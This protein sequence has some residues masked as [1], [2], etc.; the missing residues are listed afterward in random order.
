N[1]GSHPADKTT[2]IV[3]SKGQDILRNYRSIA[4]LTIVSAAIIA[5]SFGPLYY[6]SITILICYYLLLAIGW[7][8]VAGYTGLPSFAQAAFANLAGYASALAISYTNLPVFFGI[9]V[10]FLAIGGAA[11]VVGYGSVRLTGS[12]LALATISFSEG[13]RHTLS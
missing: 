7:N 2:G 8:I 3:W 6:L 9:L 4:L 13:V 1:P 12:Y 10:G 5:A 11:A